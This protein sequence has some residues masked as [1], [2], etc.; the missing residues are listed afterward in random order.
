MYIDKTLTTKNYWISPN[1][2]IIKSSN[3][4]SYAKQRFPK[5]EDPY[6]EM[7][8]HKY[9]KVIVE[10]LPEIYVHHMVG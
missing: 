2:E 8:R 5:A 6:K 7:F 3:H 9:V 10:P 4:L 1:G